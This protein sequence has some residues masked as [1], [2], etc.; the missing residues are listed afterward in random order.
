MFGSRWAYQSRQR[1]RWYG[2]R[3]RSRRCRAPFEAIVPFAAL[4]ELQCVDRREARVSGSRRPWP[5][6]GGAVRV[7]RRF[8]HET[9]SRGR[10]ARPGRTSI[11]VAGFGPLEA[12]SGH[13]PKGVKTARGPFAGKDDARLGAKVPTSPRQERDDRSRRRSI[14]CPGARRTIRESVDGRNGLGDRL[15]RVAHPDRQHLMA[16]A[17]HRRV[18]PRCE[19][20]GWRNGPAVSARGDLASAPRSWCGR[21]LAH[22][23]SR[24]GGVSEP[25]RP[26][27]IRAIS[28]SPPW[29]SARR[30][31]RM[32]YGGDR[33]LQRPVRPPPH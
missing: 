4:G 22:R 28:G 17:V 12:A 9:K 33:R 25:A 11:G 20:L 1:R 16:C 21:Q 14:A 10:P 2:P 18:R 13:T 30:Q 26:V 23:D 29:A 5:T 19:P 32:S 6:S 24:V 15:C 8:L 3:W 27:N 7:L 31:S